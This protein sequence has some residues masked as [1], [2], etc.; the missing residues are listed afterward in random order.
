MGH[1]G[2]SCSIVVLSPD[3]GGR[4]LRQTNSHRQQNFAQRATLLFCHH[5]LE[6]WSFIPGRL[7]IAVFPTPGGM[8]GIEEL[9]D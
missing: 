1:Q 8:G 4:L 2:E 3:H 6:L 5:K 7:C 9:F